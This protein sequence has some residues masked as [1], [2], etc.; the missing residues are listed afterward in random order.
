[1]IAL[2][3]LGMV[4]FGGWRWSG[5]RSVERTTRVFLAAMVHGDAETLVGQMEGP[6]LES[7]L[8]KSPEEQE[9]LTAPIPG[10]EYAIR[11]VHVNGSSARVRVLWKVSGFDIWSDLELAKAAL[12]HWKITAI[13]QPQM[14]PT[15]EQVRKHL[16]EESQAAAVPAHETLSEQ[17]A[18]QEGV[19][20][21]PLSAG[22]LDQ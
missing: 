19:E 18:G 15:W 4:A 10:A 16:A 8:A 20:V 12:C 17:L 9:A 11:E 3:V 1:V 13:K 2:I 22:E 7:Y 21:R 5:K 14:I 6:A